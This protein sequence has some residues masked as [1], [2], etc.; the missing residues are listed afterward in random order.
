MGVELFKTQNF[1]VAQITT[2]NLNK[3]LTGLS[4]QNANDYFTAE[5]IYEG[6]AVECRTED[7]HWLVLAF[8]YPD[9]DNTFSYK[10]VNT[11]IEDYCYN[12]TRV[13]EFR[14]CLAAAYDIITEALKTGFK[15]MK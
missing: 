8:V 2:I 3:D 15:E 12:W 14:T 11:R 4:I 7:N 13:M 6:V 9:E 5:P 1:R 10:S